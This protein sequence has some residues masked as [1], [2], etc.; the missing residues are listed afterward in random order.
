MRRTLTTVLLALS[1]LL[2]TACAPAITYPLEEGVMTS[3]SAANEPVPTLM[4]KAIEYAH[5]EWGE[6]GD[7]RL[8]VGHPLEDPD[9]PA[10]HVTRVSSQGNE[11]LIDLFHPKPDGTYGYVT[12]TFRLQLIGGYQHLTTRTWQTGDQPPPPAYPET[13]VGTSPEE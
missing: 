6:E 9:E 3:R 7:Q 11:A 10:Y 5:T 8:G 4:A 1:G 12:L 2:T 13:V